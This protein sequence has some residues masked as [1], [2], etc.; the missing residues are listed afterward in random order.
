MPEISA[1]ARWLV[2]GGLGWLA[3]AVITVFTAAT[4]GLNPIDQRLAASV[5]GFAGGAAIFVA[6]SG[7]M[8][9]AF[10]AVT[11]AALAAAGLL[12]RTRRGLGSVV[13]LVSAAATA[14]TVYLLRVAIGR[15]GPSSDL[16]A[17]APVDFTFPSGP[18]TYAMVVC[19]LA[20]LLATRRVWRP[21]GRTVA[22]TS[23]VG[24][25]LVIGLGR[26]YLGYDWPTD[27]LAGWLLAGGV[28]CTAYGSLL[29]LDNQP[30]LSGGSKDD[31]IQTP[32]G[33]LA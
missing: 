19:V 24:L 31:R 21:L 7:A 15:V 3:F 2:T 5:P 29:L 9:S 22:V 28:V 12:A 17:G 1:G 14:S 23:A 4:G 16:L 11:L 13:M 32:A 27:V 6:R 8:L 20:T 10:P 25:A 18:T 26:I 30:D 33:A